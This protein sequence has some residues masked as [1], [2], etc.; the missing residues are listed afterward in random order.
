MEDSDLAYS[1]MDTPFHR[2]VVGE[3]LPGARKRDIKIDLYF[4][5]IPT[6]TTPISAPIPTIPSRSTSSNV[7]T[8]DYATAKKRLGDREV[9]VPDPTPAEVN[10]MIARHRA[11]LSELLTR[12]GTIDMLCLD[13]WLGLKVWPQL[14]ETI[15]HL[16]KLQPDVMLRGRGIGNYGDYYTPE[17]VVPGDKGNTDTPWF[18]IYPLG[19][20]FSYERVAENHKGAGW[21]VRNLV[22][23]VAKGGNFMVGIGPDGDGRF[24]PTAV[25]QLKEAGE[26]LNVNGAA[27]YA[28]RARDGELWSEGADIRFTRTKDNRTVYAFTLKWPGET[29]LLRSVR[30][31]E[32]SAIRM[33]GADTP[34]PWMAQGSGVEI[35]IPPALQD[36][37]RRPCRFAWCFQIRTEAA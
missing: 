6:G 33:L 32:G 30:P 20:S 7:L 29:L 26:W 2:D 27:I 5:S 14:R 8:M 11:Q 21:V 10:R 9:I 3:L 16:R 34:L 13:M 37:S 28:T 4:L 12:Y 36:E 17:G 22:D 25:S 18:V 19:S 1:I 23:S 35:R 15:L 31:V 24:H